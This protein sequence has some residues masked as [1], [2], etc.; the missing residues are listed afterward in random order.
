MFP[1]TS[2]DIISFNTLG[3]GKKRVKAVSQLDAVHKKSAARGK[4]FAEDEDDAFKDLEP[5]LDELFAM[6]EEL[7]C[8]C[9]TP[10]GSYV[11]SLPLRFVGCRRANTAQRTMRIHGQSF[12]QAE[13]WDFEDDIANDDIETNVNREEAED[14]QEEE[15]AELEREHEELEKVLKKEGRVDKEEKDEDEGYKMDLDE[16][17]RE[18]AMPTV[19]QAR[20]LEKQQEMEGRKHMDK[21]RKRTKVRFLAR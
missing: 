2:G 10:I 17:E 7:V 21:L 14:A 20:L 12:M 19:A 9:P 11:F 6:D 4:K 3:E 8:C 16:D 18:E 15:H 1:D 5:E 13:G